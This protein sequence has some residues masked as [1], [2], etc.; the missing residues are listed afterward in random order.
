MKKFKKYIIAILTIVL[1]SEMYFYPFQGMFRFSAGV[2]AISLAILIEE[3]LDESYL[4]VFTGIFVVIFRTLVGYI[5]TYDSLYISY[6]YAYPVFFYYTAFGVLSKLF[7]LREKSNDSSNVIFSLFCIDFISN[8]F[9]I[10]FRDDMNIKIIKYSISIAALRSLISYGIFVIFRNQELII[11]ENEHQK[12]YAQ[13]NK[14]ASDIQAETFYLKKSMK[15]IESV[16][17]KSHLLYM[18]NRDNENISSLSLDIAREVHEI[19]KDYYR[20]IAGLEDFIKDFE[21]NDEMSFK[22]IIYIIKINVDKYIKESNK[23]I[24]INFS[25]KDNIDI[26]NYYYIFTILNNLIVNAIDEVS[27]EGRIYVS[28]YIENDNIIL[29]IRDNGEGVDEGLLDYIFNPGFTTK[30]DNVTGKPSTGI[31]LSHVKNI[32]ENLNGEIEIVSKEKKG[33]TFIIK[34]PINS[35]RG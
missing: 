1:F 30:Y 9:E 13:L 33:T 34:V 11:M 3:D 31:G 19:K 12:R 2:L 14:I 25:V 18:D 22:D 21:E 8:V 7:S 32:V 10:I 28:Q 17:S 4:G 16:M 20:I 6:S 23:D 5:N 24:D 26:K 29:K 15:D 35:L 27:T